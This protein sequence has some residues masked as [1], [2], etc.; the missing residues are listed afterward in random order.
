MAFEL[1]KNIQKKITKEIHKAYEVNEYTLN[2]I[3]ISDSINAQLPLK[4]WKNSFFEIKNNSQ[5]IGYAF[6][7]KADSKTDEFDYLVLFDTELIIKKTKVLVYREDYG[8]EIG[9]KRWLQQF[10]GKDK[11][12][13]L[14]YGRDI[15]A[16]SGATISAR[17][18]TIAINKLMKSIEILTQNN[19]I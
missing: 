8:G 19:F 7:S 13:D 11:K 18:F 9:S 6:V 15:I 14:K 2:P 3:L 16:I 10:I 4:I 12:D 5:L 17:S 1:P